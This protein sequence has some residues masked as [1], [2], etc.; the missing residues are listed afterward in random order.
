MGVVLVRN[1]KDVWGAAS[2]LI[3]HIIC[4]AIK[5]SKRGKYIEKFKS[6]FDDG[7][8]LISFFDLEYIDKMDFY[9][10]VCEYLNES[11]FSVLHYKDPEVREALID[12]ISRMEED[13]RRS[14]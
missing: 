9:H 3:Y 14:Q 1:E 2:N 12:L 4:F 13:I 6:M 7:Y 5:H 8:N 11:V 10:I